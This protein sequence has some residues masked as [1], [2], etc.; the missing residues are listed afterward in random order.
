[1]KIFS[2]LIKQRSK[3]ESK[4]LNSVMLTKKENKN[5]EIIIKKT[6]RFNINVRYKI[7]EILEFYNNELFS[8]NVYKNC[9]KRFAK[10]NNLFMNNIKKYYI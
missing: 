6:I 8:I 10:T 1:M 9:Q 7:I 4:M 5:F 3:L 2:Q